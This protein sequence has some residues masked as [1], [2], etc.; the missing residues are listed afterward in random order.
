[1]NIHNADRYLDE[2][3]PVKTPA[4]PVPPPAPQPQAEPPVPQPHA[5]APAPQLHAE[6]PVP[7]PPVVQA[8]RVVPS[9]DTFRK[10]RQAAAAFKRGLRRGVTFVQEDR[11]AADRAEDKASFSKNEGLAETRDKKDILV[12]TNGE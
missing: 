4:L 10:V 2:A 8:D 11:K 3:A 7:E 6:P 5:E 9:A 12:L 1:M